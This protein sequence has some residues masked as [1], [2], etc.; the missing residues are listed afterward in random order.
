MT[1]HAL[2]NSYLQCLPSGDLSVIASL[3]GECL[4]C[5]ALGVAPT[6][7]VMSKE[8][9]LVNTGHPLN[10]GSDGHVFIRIHVSLLCF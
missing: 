2:K 4:E 7:F 10:K 9:N 6:T 3:P 1:L 5:L 8:D